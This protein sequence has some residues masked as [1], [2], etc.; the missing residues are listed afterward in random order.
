MT[1]IP[2]VAVLVV[3]LIVISVLLS[4]RGRGFADFCKLLA[5]GLRSGFS[6]HQ[7]FFLSRIAKAA[8]L[9]KYSSI[10][11]SSAALDKCTAEIIRQAKNAS[12]ENRESVQKILSALYECRRKMDL[13]QSRKKRGIETTRDIKA[14]Q[15]MYIVFSG[16]GSFSAKV[17]ENSPA[18]LTVDFPRA[19]SVMATK[20]DWNNK[21]LKVF[22]YRANDAG[23]EFHTSV[24]PLDS[25]DKRAVLRLKHSDKVARFQMRKS[26]R[27]KCSIPAQLYIIKDNASALEL[28]SEPGME[29]VLQ[30]LS[31]TGAMIFIGSKAFRG[32][33][34]KI[35]F[36][37]QDT[38][39]IM[40]G[41]AKAVDY[42]AAKNTSLI[43]FECSEM[44]PKM[45]N[46]ILAF[47]YNV[48][49]E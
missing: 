31:D 24:I 32:M 28:E 9:A 48:S 23:Y 5:A 12:A 42:N 49:D 1:I 8:G 16:A 37:I 44:D 33:K 47:V 11:K 10:F 17:I 43:H 41:T 19:P 7:V 46:E 15:P 21:P 36:M 4:D 39:I 26:T 22:F 34:I 35:Q 40:H 20:I 27:V 6:V 30:D 13:E 45:K 2:I 38:L 3:L 29:C 18:C 25:G 14:G